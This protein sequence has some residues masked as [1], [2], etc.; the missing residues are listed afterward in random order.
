M[1]VSHPPH[2]TAHTSGW[3]EIYFYRGLYVTATQPILTKTQEISEEW[4]KC[5]FKVR[6]INSTGN[7]SVAYH[8]PQN[9]RKESTGFG[10]E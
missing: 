5:G 10:E 9:N 4:E 8:Q 6:E 1:E 3:Q 2:Q 7:T